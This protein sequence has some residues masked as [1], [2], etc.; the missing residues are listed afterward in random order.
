[1][2]K[3]SLLG[4]SI[5]RIDAR[6]KVTGQAHY[7]GDLTMPGM[8]HAKVLFARRPH[9][10]VRHIDI[11]AALALPG[12]LGIFT[13]ADVP[14]NEYGLVLFDAPVMV[15]A[16]ENGSLAAENAPNAKSF[17]GIVR[18]IGEKWRLLWPKLKKSP[19]MPAA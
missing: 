11:S 18:H 12:V 2:Q 14:N 15:S 10:R 4:Q 7:P 6:A 13:G 17:D 5:T 3:P 8:A 1:M 9:A 16:L 19:S